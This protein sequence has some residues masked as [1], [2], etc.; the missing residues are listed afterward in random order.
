MRLL[1]IDTAIL[2]YIFTMRFIYLLLFFKATYHR[3]SRFGLCGI[4][5]SSFK[6]ENCQISDD[7]VG[8]IENTCQSYCSTDSSCK[9]FDFKSGKNG[10]GCTVYT[11][12]TCRAEYN[13][14][15]RGYTGD[16]IQDTIYLAGNHHYSG[17]FKKMSGNTPLK[18]T[19]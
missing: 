10:N 14:V 17:C 13:K 16:L 1:N 8:N 6:P 11:T 7:M 9:G 3:L 15:S 5:G 2:V 18:F 19:N 4:S 12:S